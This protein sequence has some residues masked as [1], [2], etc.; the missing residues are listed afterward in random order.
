M[1]DTMNIGTYNVHGINDT[2]WEYVEHL[3][4]DCEFLCIQEHWLHSSQFHVFTDNIPNIGYHCVSGMDD[5]TFIGGRPYGGC[6]V[7]WQNSIRCKIEPVPAF[8]KRLCVVKVIMD[9]QTLMV[10]TVYMPCDTEH[11]INNG[12]IFDDVLNEIIS[13]SET[14]GVDHIICAGDFNTDISRSNSLHTRKLLSF[15]SVNNMVLLDNCEIFDVNYTYESMANGAKSTIDHF[16]VTNNLSNTCIN[17]SC[18]HHANNLSDHSALTV[19]FN[20]NYEEHKTEVAPQN[21]LLWCQASESELSQYRDKL[22]KLLDN[23]ELPDPA[24]YCTDLFCKDHNEDIQLF[25]DNI[26]NAC[27]N[28]S[29]I[30]PQSSKSSKKRIPGWNEYV[31]PFKESAFFWHKIWKENGSPNIGVIYD[32]RRKTRYQYHNAIRTTHRNKHA[33]TMSNMANAF[34][35]STKRN[36]WAEVK[37]L[38]GRSS[39]VPDVIDNVHGEHDIANL[40]KDKYREL[41]N[42]VSYDARQMSVLRSDIELLVSNHNGI[43]CNHMVNVTDVIDGIHCLKS[44]KHDGNKGSFS[45]HLIHGNIKL[46]VYISLLFDSMLLHGFAPSDFLL[47]T[48]VPIPKNKRKSLNLSDNYRAIALSSI[49]GKLLDNIILVKCQNI[50]HTTDLQFGFKKN[51]STSQCTFVVNEVL[52]YYYNNGSNVYLTLLDASKAFDRVEYIKLFRLLVNKGI[53]PIIARFLVA[54]YTNQTV[55]VKWGNCLSESYPV[56]NGVKQGGVL[57]PLLFTVYIDEL[58]IRLGKSSYGCY[59]G[60]QFCGAFGYADDV[61]LMA[62]TVYSLKYMLA[63]CANYAKE[64]NVLFNS[65]KSKLILNKCRYSSVTAPNVEFMNGPIEIVKWDKHLGNPIGNISSKEFVDI[66][67]SEFMSK[68]NMVKYHFSGLPVNQIYSLFKT[69]CMPLYGSQLWDLDNISVERF[70]VTWRKAIRYLLNIP[71]STHC[72]LLPLICDDMEIKCQIFSRFR[73]FFRSLSYSSNDVIQLCTKLIVAGSNSAVS[74]SLSVV[75]KY[76]NVSR[77]ELNS[78]YD[79]IDNKEYTINDITNASVIV[80]LLDIKNGSLFVTTS[81]SKTCCDLLINELCVN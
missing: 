48:L 8:S 67:I 46:Q 31:A 52:Q 76:A 43:D 17:I 42:S 28:A 16:M 39:S 33:I 51:H 15:T 74:N 65:N 70:Y 18:D 11:D 7:L 41:Y 37:K 19:R 78:T 80:E 68:V 27:I 57:S 69:Y 66:C 4:N 34:T 20:M 77:Y 6:G 10:C 56:T 58:L 64:Y 62:P 3:M 59:V 22:D 75:S 38:R 25:H 36:F 1:R 45:N 73:S 61:V 14:I 24:L 12:N 47:S 71:Y 29:D 2:K 21:K 35:S 44:D 26:I 53:C 32:I 13:I 49:L 30:I 72:S 63:I 81:F 50:F 54:L 40:F 9:N 60:T 5:G 55:R 79:V 23:I